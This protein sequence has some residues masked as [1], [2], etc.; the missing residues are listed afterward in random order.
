MNDKIG[1]SAWIFF[2]S[3]FSF[4]F[5]NH[6]F[7]SSRAPIKSKNSTSGGWLTCKDTED[8]VLTL[9]NPFTRR[10]IPLPA[11]VKEERVDGRSW[12][13]QIKKVVLSADPC[14]F[15]NDFEALGLHRDFELSS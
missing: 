9:F 10:T 14:L 12:A 6:L 11:A 3:F 4:F 2:F 8:L 15:C 1:V 7:E 5:S 13:F